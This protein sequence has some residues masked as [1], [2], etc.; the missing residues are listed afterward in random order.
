M[1]TGFLHTRSAERK[2]RT[3]HQDQP[4]YQTICLK[5]CVG[6]GAHT[7]TTCHVC[8]SSRDLPQMAPF[9]SLTSFQFR[10]D[11]HTG[12]TRKCSAELDEAT[13]NF[14]ERICEIHAKNYTSLATNELTKI[15]ALMSEAGEIFDETKLRETLQEAKKHAFNKAREIRR[16]KNQNKQ[17]EKN[18]SKR[19]RSPS[20][21]RSRERR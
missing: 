4:K 11:P 17:K 1:K 7:H 15:N 20:R 8:A 12:I 6:T 19:K 18:A 14:K 16:R 13:Q 3:H 2:P 9:P 10:E 5:T 21:G